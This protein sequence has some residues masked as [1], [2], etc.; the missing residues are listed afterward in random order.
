[1]LKRIALS[2]SLAVFGL[3]IVAPTP[4]QA[5]TGWWLEYRNVSSGKCIDVKD[6]ST[7]NGAMIQEYTCKSPVGSGAENQEWQWQASG[8]HGQFVNEHSFK[9]ME[10]INGSLA[11]G[12]P[13]WQWACTGSTKQQW[14]TIF[15]SEAH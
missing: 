1:M 10:L 9:C 2:I 11:D 13:V 7:G 8:T 3:A 6:S 14:D 5:D 15:V 4:A 12:A